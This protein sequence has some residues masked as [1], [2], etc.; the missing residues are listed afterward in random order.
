LCIEYLF[1]LNL[2]HAYERGPFFLPK[3]KVHFNK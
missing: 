2:G 3:S 1:L